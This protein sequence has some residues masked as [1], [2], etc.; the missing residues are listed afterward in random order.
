M[1]STPDVAEMKWKGKWSWYTS[2]GQRSPTPPSHP[3]PPLPQDLAWTIPDTQRLPHSAPSHSRHSHSH[4]STHHSAA[5]TE[6][7]TTPQPTPSASLLLAK[8]TTNPQT[9]KN[10]QKQCNSQL[11]ENT[12]SWILHQMWCGLLQARVWVVCEK[13]GMRKVW[14]DSERRE[15]EMEKTKDK[16]VH[17]AK[18]RAAPPLHSPT[19]SSTNF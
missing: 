16:W 3:W 9:H 19:P 7:P 2:L 14:W 13:G 5:E 11:S 18:W 12:E 10:A 8:K 6:T 1:E 4:T 15:E 17:V